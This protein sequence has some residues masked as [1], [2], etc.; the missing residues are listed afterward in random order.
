ME[1]SALIVA[2]GSGTRMNLGYNKV[3]Y[4]LDDRTVLEHAMDVFLEDDDCKQVIIVTNACDF[5]KHYSKKLCGKI[6]LCEGG[7]T[8]MESV[9]NG[10]NAVSEDVVFVHDGARPYVQM[11]EVE[12]LKKAMEEEQAALLC[13]PCV[14][15]MKKINGEYIETTMDRSELVH[16]QTPQAFHTSL[17]M[18]C[19]MQAKKDGDITTDD[20]GLVEKYSDVSIKVVMG[21]YANKK[22]T[23][24]DDLS[25]K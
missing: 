21:S 2:A 3:Y 4:K 13:V 23:T 9:S 7:N 14:D 1:Y 6:V 11:E 18:D 22:M 24:V 17:L 15:T 19:M 8:R 10:L 25:E 5:M 16:A 20:A 12:R